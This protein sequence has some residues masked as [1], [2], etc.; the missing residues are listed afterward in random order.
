M[1]QANGQ[2]FTPRSVNIHKKGK[3]DPDTLQDVLVD[4]KNCLVE[5]SVDIKEMREKQLQMESKL[6]PVV[7]FHKKVLIVAS[8]FAV[9]VTMLMG[10]L[11]AYIKAKFFN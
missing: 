4:I 1:A 9:P 2:T 5:Q 7:D 6:E 8:I 11:G 10:W 3:V